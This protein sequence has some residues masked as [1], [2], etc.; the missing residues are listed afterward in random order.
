MQFHAYVNTNPSSK[1]QYPYLLDVQNSLLADLKTRL[2]IPLTA[3]AS[4]RSGVI[5]KLC[6]VLDINGETFV[7]LTQQMAGIESRL[8]GAKV[9]DLSAYRAEII[10]AI[11]FAV[12]GI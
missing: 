5:S 11:D 10:A 1:G 7:A 2:V 8:L 6:P 12:V 4:F 9:A 3:Q